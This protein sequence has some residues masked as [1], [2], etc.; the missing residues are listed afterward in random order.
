M[1]ADPADAFLS[2]SRH[3]R[4]VTVYFLPRE[5]FSKVTLEVKQDN[6]GPVE[7]F[8][9]GMQRTYDP[10]FVATQFQILQKTEVL[11]PVIERLDLIKEF[12]PPGTKLPLQDVYY[13]LKGS[14]KLQEVRNTGM[15]EIGAYDTDPQ[16]AANIANTIAVVY[17]ERRR[18]DLESNTT[19]GLEQ[20]QDDLE[21]QRKLVEKLSAESMKLRARDGIVDPDPD[22]D[23]SQLG[24]T[25]QTMTAVQTQESE[26]EIRVVE[27]ERQ[28]ELINNLRPE[29]LQDALKTLG[30]DDAVVA[31]N[32]PLF[33]DATAEKARLTSLGLG[34]NHP[35]IKALEA[36]MATYFQDSRRPAQYHSRTT[37]G[38]R[39][40]GTR[41]TSSATSSRWPQTPVRRRS[42]KKSQMGWLPRRQE[43]AISAPKKSSRKP[44]SFPTRPRS[45]RSP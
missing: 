31:R 4:C 22:K 7:T 29:E 42:P 10:Q 18:A 15:I 43:Q 33:Q 14:M 9:A 35:R 2:W 1:G 39:L 24:H 27:L 36:Q 45:S 17:Q 8:G 38:T 3:R 12:S 32:L 44:R 37:Q 41:R 28:L 13:R 30:I 25:T 19:M 40:P 34:T 20:L 6:S 11:Y 16:W 26:Q 5:Y 21:Q 23:N